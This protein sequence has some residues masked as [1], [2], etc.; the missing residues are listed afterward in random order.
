[1]KKIA[2]VCIALLGL[3]A[4]PAFA[5]EWGAPKVLNAEL[6]ADLG[7]GWIGGSAGAELGL[8]QWNLGP[9]FKLNF[10]VKGAAGVD[11][12]FLSAGIRLGVGAYGVLHYPIKQLN[13]GIDFLNKLDYWLGLGVGLHILSTFYPTPAYTSGVSYDLNSNLAVY[14]GYNE[15]GGSSFGIKTTF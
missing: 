11:L 7:F 10:G 9:Q 1:M 6:G 5:A 14:A 15:F 2:L 3:L 13:T 12:D 4:A 8:F